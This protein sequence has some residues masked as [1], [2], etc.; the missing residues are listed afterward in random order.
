MSN[1]ERR[2]IVPAAVVGCLPTGELR[3]SLWPSR[4]A[5]KPGFPRD[6]PVD[7][8]PPDLRMPNSTLWLDMD[9][10]GRS[11]SAASAYRLLSQSRGVEDGT[12]GPAGGAGERG[13]ICLRRHN[14][15][16]QYNRSN[17]PSIC[18]DDQ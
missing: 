4:N 18:W 11:D 6:V 12:S 16:D 15:C 5:D 8:I 1:R 2:K 13:H 3:L 14:L 17:R 9:K 10:G 7:L